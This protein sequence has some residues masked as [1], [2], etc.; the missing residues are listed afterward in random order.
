MLTFARVINKIVESIINLKNKN[1]YE[2][3]YDVCRYDG[4]YSKC[5]CPV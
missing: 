1:D 5:K 3:D 2:E 4:G